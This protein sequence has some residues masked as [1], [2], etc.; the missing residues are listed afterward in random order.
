MTNLT[1]IIWMKLS[2]KENFVSYVLIFGKRF[3][4]SRENSYLSENSKFWS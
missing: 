3:K 1:S 2:V 4:Y